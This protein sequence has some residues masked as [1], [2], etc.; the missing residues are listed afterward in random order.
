MCIRKMFSANYWFDIFIINFAK[1]VN[2][3]YYHILL[4]VNLLNFFTVFK[5]ILILFNVFDSIAIYDII[6]S[7]M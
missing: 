6:V 4:N 7:F 3:L 2:R 1:I 5:I